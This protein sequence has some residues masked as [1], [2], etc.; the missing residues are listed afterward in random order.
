MIFQLSSVP[1]QINVVFVNDGSR[2]S[3]SNNQSRLF[4]GWKSLKKAC[5]NNEM[6]Q[7]RRRKQGTFKRITEHML[8]SNGTRN[9]EQQLRI[10]TLNV[11]SMT[12]RSLELEHLMKRRRL[13][14]MC[15]QETRWGNKGNKSR[16]LDLKTKQYKL[17]YHGID[18]QRKRN[19][20][21]HRK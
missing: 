6:A 17:F 10:G 5:L 7:R 20:H 14:V 15:V 1:H 11:G 18:N 21:H 8:T 4:K 3:K 16:F 2:R 13:D 9:T 19:R 12:K